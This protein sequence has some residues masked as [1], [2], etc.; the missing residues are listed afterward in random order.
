[1]ATIHVRD[2]PENERYVAEIGDEVVAYTVYHLRH[3]NLYFFPHTQV[4]QGYSGQGI[5][6][7][8][9]RS[10]LDDVESKGGKIVPLCP[11]I[12]GFLRKNPEYDDLV[13]HEVFDRIA[14]RL[15]PE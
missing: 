14:E 11:Y 6:E 7:T 15:H 8:L 12:A 1:M 3:G 9:V 2:D 13:D 5:A 10:A 4:E